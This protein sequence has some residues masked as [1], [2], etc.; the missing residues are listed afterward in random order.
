MGVR[1][2]WSTASGLSSGASHDRDEVADWQSRM[3]T[4]H[5]LL[6]TGSFTQGLGTFGGTR[7]FTTVTRV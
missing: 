4:T 5:R 6:T 1:Y 3:P 7:V 2:G